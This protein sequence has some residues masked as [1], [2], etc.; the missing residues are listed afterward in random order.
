MLVGFL[1]Q[2]RWAHLNWH[3]RLYAAGTMALAI[4]TLFA[5]LRPADIPVTRP[6][7]RNVASEP[8][9]KSAM[10]PTL[11]NYEMV[12]KLSSEKFDEFLTEQ[13]SK[14]LSPT[15][16]YRAVALPWTTGAD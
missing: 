7:T 11:S 9:A 8:Q 14:N 6:P 16:V 3:L 10:D 2:F 1:Q 15:P 4:V 12:A 5:F 13:G